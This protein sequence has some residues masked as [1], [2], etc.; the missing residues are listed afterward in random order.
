MRNM[1]IIPILHMLHWLPVYS[2]VQLKVLVITR[3]ALH[4]VGA[5]YLQ[6]CLSQYVPLMS[7]ISWNC[8]STKCKNSGLYLSFLFCCLYQ[9]EWPA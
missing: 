3:K 9:A 7:K 8:H 1:Y 2:W 4:W 6:D 5:T